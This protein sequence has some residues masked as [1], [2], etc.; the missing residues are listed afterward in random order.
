MQFAQKYAADG[1]VVTAAS[2][3]IVVRRPSSV[4]HRPC[5]RGFKTTARVVIRLD[6]MPDGTTTGDK[7]SDCTTTNVTAS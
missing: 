5:L 4:V 6:D 2:D 1:V 3:Y 7:M